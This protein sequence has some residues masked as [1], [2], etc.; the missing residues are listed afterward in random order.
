M[1]ICTACGCVFDKPS[2]YREYHTELDGN[3]YETF[4]CCPS[5]QDTGYEEAVECDV[6]GDIVPQSEMAVMG[7]AGCEVRVCQHCRKFNDELEE[8]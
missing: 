5:C 8:I 6:C 2:S 3:P 7:L 1:Y 4:S